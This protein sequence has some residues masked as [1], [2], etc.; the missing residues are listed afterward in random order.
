MKTTQRIPRWECSYCNHSNLEETRVCEKCGFIVGCFGYRYGYHPHCKQ[1]PS[2][3]GCQKYNQM[4][5][6]NANPSRR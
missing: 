1:C 3:I 6:K 5:E 4:Y 2:R